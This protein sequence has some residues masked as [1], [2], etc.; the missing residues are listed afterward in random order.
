MQ[1]QNVD[2][3]IKTN[4]IEKLIGIAKNL[5]VSINDII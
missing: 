1:K 5:S 4:S 3:L 2:A